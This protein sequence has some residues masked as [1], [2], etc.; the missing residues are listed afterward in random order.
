MPLKA[1]LLSRLQTKHIDCAGFENLTNFNKAELLKADTNL[2][3]ANRDYIKRAKGVTDMRKTK[4]TRKK[5]VKELKIK[6][7]D[8]KYKVMVALADA[9]A[10]T[11]KQRA[12]VITEF[13][14]GIR[15]IGK[16]S[17][18]KGQELLMN[19][20]KVAD[21]NAFERKQAL[22]NALIKTLDNIVDRST[23]EKL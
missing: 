6:I 9:L 2:V 7:S 20:K 23:P 22:Y 19:A 18:A 13:E 4:L 14:A 16:G 8:A 3:G 21:E 5:V 10:K 1:E 17:T 12:G 11:Q 15:A